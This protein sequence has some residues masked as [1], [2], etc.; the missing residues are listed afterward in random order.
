MSEQNKPN[1]AEAAF[2]ILSRKEDEDNLSEA[3]RLVEE[4]MTKLRIA[5]L[6]LSEQ[7]SG[8]AQS[9]GKVNSATLERLTRMARINLRRSLFS[10]VFGG[11]ILVFGLAYPFLLALADSY[12]LLRPRVEIF[13]PYN[14]W[15]VVILFSVA[16][17]YFTLKASRFYIRSRHHI[18]EIE[19]IRK[20]FGATPTQ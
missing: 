14:L 10:M 19:K 15:L 5:Q 11:L 13:A 3:L 18:L 16:G 17:A 7:S 8:E 2:P 4:A 6:S 12:N 9:T 1:S 20:S